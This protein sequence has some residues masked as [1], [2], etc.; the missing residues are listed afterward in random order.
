[1]ISRYQQRVLPFSEFI[2]LMA[3][4]MSLVAL[5]IDA[6]LPALE[7]IGT[8]FGVTNANDNQLLIGSLF[9][10]MAFGQLFFGPL[11]DSIGR[12]RSMTIGFSVFFIGSV[13][14]LL[15]D[16]FETMLISRFL[17][18]LGVAAP[19]A[20]STAIVRD[21]YE[22]RA[23]ARVMSFIMMIFILVPML[24]PAFGQIILTMANW[25]A[26]FIVIALIGLISLAWYLLRQGETLAEE[27]QAD[28]TVSR[29]LGALGT[30]FSNRV[31]LGYTIAAGIISGPFIFY[32]SS[33]QQ[34]FQHAYE[35]GEWFPA[36]FAGLALAF[37]MS[38]YINGKQ[39][40]HFGMHRIVRFA[41]NLMTVSSFLFIFVTWWFNGLPALWITTIYMLLT[42]FCIGLIF[43]NLNALAMQPLGHIAGIGAAVVGSLST[44]IAVTMAV[45]I[46]RYFDGTVH[47][48]VIG[49]FVSGLATLA[50]MSWI[51]NKHEVPVI[52]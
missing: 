4:M 41:L 9:I 15:A 19:R 36:Y 21:L 12:R 37:G 3:L 18:G 34:L 26:I 40:M 35:L 24:A 30:I 8:S 47:P 13:M 49:F 44:F 16:T 5:S 45:I 23:M 39:V 2:T 22:G 29:T 32:L 20:V 52:S 43:G 42:F 1:M 25:Q 51:G 11:S 31:A 28:F 6:V 50:L 17:Q 46:G 27:D 7:S 10:G 38:S 14:A 48:Q 33:A